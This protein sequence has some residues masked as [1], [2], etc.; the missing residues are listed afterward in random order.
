MAVVVP[1]S[2][3]PARRSWRLWPLQVFCMLGAVGSNCVP[4]G[5]GTT[6]GTDT[7]RLDRTGYAAVVFINRSS[8]LVQD[9][10]S[11]E[12]QNVKPQVWVTPVTPDSWDAL[13][14]DFP[15]QRIT[16]IGVTPVDLQTG[17][18]GEQVL[19]KDGAYANRDRVTCGSIIVVRTSDD[20]AKPGAVLINVAT[21]PDSGG[22]DF[23]LAGSSATSPGAQ[24]GLLVIRPEVPEDVSARA[25]FT[26]ENGAGQ[27]FAS[28]WEIRGV[29]AGTASLVECPVKRVGWGNLRDPSLAGATLDNPT[30]ELPAP[31][32]LRIAT[33]DGTSSPTGSFNCGDTINLVLARDSA[34]ESGFRLDAQP[35]SDGSA[36]PAG[37]ID[38]FGNLRRLLDN[39]GMAGRLS[40]TGLLLPPP[41]G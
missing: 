9:I 34:A 41:P 2:S 13:L 4:A 27:V 35:E 17:L 24:S 38:L 5:D 40:N 15:F 14:I 21:I 29:G 18:A 12:H 26:W 7:S 10:I 33:D 39:E 20:P 32:A 11:V 3:K 6:P 19:Y 30:V 16:V 28:S 25:S 8:Q 23:A 37:G 22:S 36:V 31:I 1:N